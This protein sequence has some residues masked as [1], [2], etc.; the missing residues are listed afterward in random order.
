MRLVSECVRASRGRV[1]CDV[2]R[3]TIARGARYLAQTCADDAGIWDW[4]ECPACAEYRGHTRCDC[5]LYGDSCGPE[6]LEEAAEHALDLPR[7]L[8]WHLGPEGLPELEPEVKTVPRLCCEAE[9][10]DQDP[11]RAWGDD[12]W[13]AFK[14]LMRR[15]PALHPDGVTG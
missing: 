2:C 13:A 5:Y 4:V 1:R 11:A 12:A 15:S 14:W 9:E 8:V 3:R 7:E 6:C 10:W